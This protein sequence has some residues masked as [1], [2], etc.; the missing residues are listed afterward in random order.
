MDPVENY[1]PTMPEAVVRDWAQ[2]AQKELVSLRARIDELSRAYAVQGLAIEELTA[3]RDRYRYAL[4]RI[5]CEP[6]AYG[7]DM[8]MIARD[9]L[10]TRE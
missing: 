4:D 3:E 9:A 6:P 1:R 10:K 2:D 5:T 7:A 8:L